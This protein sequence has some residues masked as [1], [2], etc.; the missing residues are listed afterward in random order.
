MPRLPKSWATSTKV[1]W[2]LP[3]RVGIDELEPSPV[4][5]LRRE[6]GLIPVAGD[7]VGGDTDVVVDVTDACRLDRD[8]FLLDHRKRPLRVGLSRIAEVGPTE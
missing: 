2:E 4:D 5:L 1:L 6:H 7:L 3:L 8:R